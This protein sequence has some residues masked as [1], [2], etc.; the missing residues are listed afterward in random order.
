MAFSYE[1]DHQ[2]RRMITHMSGPIHYED[3]VAHMNAEVR[4][5]GHPYEELIDA[6]NATAKFSSE[7][8]RKF[9][10]VLERLGRESRLGPTAVV[11]SDDVTYGMVHMLGML[12]DETCAIAPFHNLDDAKR[13][14]H[15]PA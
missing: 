12:V 2:A 6:R 3:L 9:V 7:E 15:W 4:D 1:I 10:K 11:V 5:Q 13:W 8:V 14:L